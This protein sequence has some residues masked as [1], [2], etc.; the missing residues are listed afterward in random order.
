M[1]TSKHGIITQPIHVLFY[2][3]PLLT[4]VHVHELSLVLCI[5]HVQCS[6]YNIVTLFVCRSMFSASMTDA[7]TTSLQSSISDEVGALPTTHTSKPVAPHEEH[8]T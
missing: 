8:G 4:L 5:L 1:T 6:Y 3:N 7:G 2:S